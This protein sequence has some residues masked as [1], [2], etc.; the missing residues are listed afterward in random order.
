MSEA[1]CPFCASSLPADLAKHVVPDTRLRL[2][3]AA[4]YVF[5]STLALGCGARTD[6]LLRDAEGEP[7][8]TSHDAT[9]DT[10]SP[11]LDT[12]P[13]DTIPDTGVD[14]GEVRDTGGPAPI[15]KAAPFGP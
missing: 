2:H 7:D 9:V 3:R 4:L 8:A 10:S 11:T 5:A 14:T 13:V 1:C 12:A 15:Y 6:L